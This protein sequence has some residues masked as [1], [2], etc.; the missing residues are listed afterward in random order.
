MKKPLNNLIR[1][2]SIS[3]MF[4]FIGISCNTRTSTA[5]SIDKDP[6]LIIAQ[7]PTPSS[8]PAVIVNNIDYIETLPF[9][10]MFINSVS[11]WNLMN[12]QSVSYDSIYMCGI[13]P[14]KI[15]GWNQVTYLRI[16]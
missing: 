13:I 14:R 7:R 1:Y 12:G 2:V 4:L 5:V 15:V 6:L 8:Y 10:G 9:D 16:G 3:G 11:G